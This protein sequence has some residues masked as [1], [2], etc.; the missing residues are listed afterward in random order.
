MEH[1]QSVCSFTLG[2]L[3]SRG[4]LLQGE[5]GTDCSVFTGMNWSFVCV[6]QQIQIWLSERPPGGNPNF[7]KNKTFVSR[8]REAGH[9]S[10]TDMRLARTWMVNL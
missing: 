10:P 9:K 6:W 7:Q 1:A 4:R 2:L 5:V 8:D 3:C